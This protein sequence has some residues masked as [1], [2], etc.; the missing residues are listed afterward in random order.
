MGGWSHPHLGRGQEETFVSII[1]QVNEE[2]SLCKGRP[3][4]SMKGVDFT[5]NFDKDGDGKVSKDEFAGPDKIFDLHDKNQDG[6]IDESEAPKG[7][8]PRPMKGKKY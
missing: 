7:R 2:V 6:Y 3:S 1:Q 5:Q 8:Q 4:R